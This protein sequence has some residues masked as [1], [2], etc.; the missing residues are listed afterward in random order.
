MSHLFPVAFARKASR[1]RSLLSGA[2]YGLFLL[3]FGPMLQ[4][5]V[6]Y[7]G[8]VGLLNTGTLY[9]PEQMAIDGAGNIYIADELGSQIIKVPANGGVPTALHPVV[10]GMGL[11][12]AF[13][14]TADT[15]GDLYIGDTLNKRVLEIPAGGSAVQLSIGTPGGEALGEPFAIAIDAMGDL[16]IADSSNSRVVE[17]PA[18]GGTAVALNLAPNGEGLTWPEGI[19]VDAAGT[20][21]VSDTYHSRIVE[22]PYGGAAIAIIPTANGLGLSQATNLTVD[23]AGDIYIADTGNQRVVELP[24]GGGSAIALDPIFNGSGLQ[25]PSGVAVD[26][27]GNLFISDISAR[28][29]LKLQNAAVDLGSVNVLSTSTT[30][31]LTFSFSGTATLAPPVVVTQGAPNLDFKDAK[32][33]SCT[34]NGSQ[35]YSAGQ[36]CTVDVTLTPGSPGLRSGAV[37]LQS[38]DGATLAT[39]YMHGVGLGPQTAFSPATS[40]V[41]SLSGVTAHLVISSV[42]DGSGNLYIADYS[43]NQILKRTPGGTTSVLLSSANGVA[44]SNPR[45]IAIDGAGTLYIAD[46]SNNRIVELTQSGVVSTIN[47]SVNGR[48]FASPYDV[49]VDP[50]GDLFIADDYNERIVKVTPGGVATALAPVV[51]GIRF[52]GPIGIATDAAGNAYAGDYFNNRIVEITPAGAAT[53]ITAVANGKALAYPM[54][55]VVDAIG[56]LYVA[57]TGNDRVIEI[58][59][60]GTATVVLTNGVNVPGVEYL[61]L[62]INGN[63]ILPDSSSNRVVVLN[64]SNIPSLNFATATNVGST[65]ST[66]GPQTVTISNIG[67]ATLAFSGQAVDPNWQQVPSGAT[68]CVYGL[69]LLGGT[70][71]EVSLVFQPAAPGSPLTGSMSLTDNTLNA[72]GTVQAISLSGTAIQTD[73]TRTI[74]TPLPALLVAGQTVTLTAT[75]RDSNNLSSVPVG[76]V[77]FTDTTSGGSVNLAA[78][79]LDGN[80]SGRLQ[81]TPGP[82][83]HTITSSF[84]PSTT[85][86]ASSNDAAGTTFTV[87]AYGSP[88]SIAVTPALNA[89][90]AGQKDT[91]TVVALDSFGN[92]VANYNGPVTL[93]STDAAAMLSP[94]TFTNGTGTATAVFATTGVQTVT[95]IGGALNGVSGQITVQPPPKFVVTVSTD[96]TAGTI[97][98]CTDQSAANATPSLN[99]SL[100]DAI[101]ATNSLPSGVNATIAFD[102]TAFAGPQTITLLNRELELSANVAIA[103]P[104]TGSGSTLTNLLTVSGNNHSRVFEVDRGVTAALGSLAITNGATTGGQGGAGIFNAGTLNL[105]RSTLSENQVTASGTTGGAAI[106]NSGTLTVTNSALFDNHV[107]ATGEAGGGGISNYGTL[108]VINSTIANNTLQAPQAGGGGIYNA[109]GTITVT[110]TTI[111]GNNGTVGGGVAVAGGTVTLTNSI[112]AGNT[113]SQTQD[114]YGCGTQSA[115][116][117]IGGTPALGALAMN[118]GPTQTMLPQVGS[119]VLSA[120][121]YQEGEPAQDQRG[122]Q[123]PASQ[124]IDLG[125]VQVSGNGPTIATIAPASG[126]LTGGTLVTISGQGFTGA[127]GVYIGGNAATSFTV[128]NDTTIAA[129]VPVGTAGI[130]DV[131]VMA[132]PGISAVSAADK[133]TY[134]AITVGPASLSSAKVGT[135]Y[136]QAIAASGGTAPYTYSLASGSSLPAGLSLNANGSISGTAVAGGTRSFTVVATDATGA[137][138]SQQYTLAVNAATIAVLSTA[139]PNGVAGSAY[140]QKI[141]V[142]GGTAPYTFTLPPGS[143]LPAGLSLS[144][145]G[146]ISG[147]PVTAAPAKFSVVIMDSSTGNGPY[148]LTSSLSLTIAQGNATVTLG[149]LNATYDGNA[150]AAVTSTTPANLLV[151]ITYNGSSTAPTAAGSY[152]VAASI[153]DPSYTGSTSGTLV[154]G[155]ASSAITWSSPVAINYGT[156]LARPS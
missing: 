97:A 72:M 150:H 6:Q 96:P 3:A 133:Y 4:A 111:S 132:K 13:A 14:V 71:C 81:Y 53:T 138:G 129:T 118:G 18:G 146:L 95:A 11:A 83:T 17:M 79:P 94:V 61:S 108:A 64:A 34:N 135:T 38:T 57:D 27:N 105:D 70:S 80:G 116:N 131:V 127:T 142:S 85:S 29:V 103:G 134:I 68:D 73:P 88:A 130:A 144:P 152:T 123:R 126:P 58:T 59:P 78:V 137:S 93:S 101:A 51:N 77:T 154:I 147:T 55:V 107:Q 35:Q 87:A 40:S 45:G 117:F 44:L 143:S 1:S 41:Q 91:L 136:N 43:G 99:C 65:D 74:T 28:Q 156:A 24:A 114:C 119:P 145:S 21:Y 39:V 121:I 75:V 139:L 69:Q 82:G 102:P 112:V 100:R 109:S 76:S 89:A 10:N 12:Q 36:S 141:A 62:D 22:V 60:S 37:I 32:T 115:S 124:R 15:A 23:R 110:N 56:D 42:E 125:A 48:T 46:Q 9:G 2:L 148:Q 92:D 140:S 63:L 86:Y 52:N 20:L 50:S 106:V 66:D 54:G 7:Q 113:G 30:T 47:P 25:N 31:S 16:Y 8:A 90:Y 33:G 84:T 104:T 19:A 128:S 26:S 151:T 5:Q 155:A 98:N 49:A 149:G 120:G 67:N 153:A 122:L